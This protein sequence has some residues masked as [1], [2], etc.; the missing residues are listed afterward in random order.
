MT[1]H[2]N[3]ANQLCFSVY[4]VNRLFNKFYQD[5]LTDFGLTYPQYLLLTVL[6]NQDHQELRALGQELQL[7][8]N[9]L[10]PLV[11]RLEERGWVKRVHPQ[12]DKRR[13]IVSL[14][15]HAKASETSIQQA[16]AD[17]LG[18]YHLTAADYQQALALNQKL[19]AAL[20]A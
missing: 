20:D 3:L 14:T 7:N 15:D 6:W 13:L 4:N 10:T 9:T 19:I 8:S 12:T 17:C 5:A 11:K 16:L 1:T 18:Q 2:V